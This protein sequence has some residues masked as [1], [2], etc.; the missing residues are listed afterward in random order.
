M[1]KFWTIG[2]GLWYSRWW[3]RRRQRWEAGSQSS[4]DGLWC[5]RNIS[6]PT[7]PH[8]NSARGRLDGDVAPPRNSSSGTMTASTPPTATVLF[9]VVARGRRWRQAGKLTGLHRPGAV[10]PHINLSS[11]Q[12]IWT[13][14]ALI[15][16][17]PMLVPLNIF[18]S[19]HHTFLHWI[20]S[21]PKL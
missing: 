9:P 3:L 17:W 18:G 2:Y 12:T 16:Q 6:R 13:N 7:T 11:F 10:A 5:R 4:L 19:H 14:T 15:P 1:A 8:R 21:E 20:I